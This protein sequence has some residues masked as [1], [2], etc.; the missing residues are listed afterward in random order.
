MAQK[1]KLKCDLQINCIEKL[2]RRLGRI[3][4]LDDKGYGQGQIK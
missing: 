3:Q 2:A 1:E 4:I